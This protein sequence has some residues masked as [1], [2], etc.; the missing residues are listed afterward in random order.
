MIIQPALRHPLP[1]RKAR[2]R[3]EA[4]V[5]GESEHGTDALEHAFSTGVKLQV[6]GHVEASH[7]NQMWSL[8]YPT[9]R[10]LPKRNYHQLFW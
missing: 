3:P 10:N 1:R 9:W 5:L 7:K 4:W 2:G 6:K 8:S